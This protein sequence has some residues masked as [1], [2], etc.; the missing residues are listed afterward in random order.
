[1]D[2]REVAQERALAWSEDARLLQA[3]AVEGEHGAA[4]GFVAEEEVPDRGFWHR[5][6]EDSEWGD[7]SAEV[8]MFRFVDERDRSRGLEVVV[9]RQGEVLSVERVEP[10]SSLE[11]V[12]GW[13][14]DS[15]EAVEAALVENRAL[16]EASERETFGLV[17]LLEQEPGREAP[18]WVIAGGGGDAKAGGGG[19][20]RVDSVS[21]EIVESW[22]GFGGDG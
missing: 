11:P 9:D 3:A 1:M 18:T 10:P 21:G 8:W 12:A 4:A 14:V 19:L 5:A 22:G 17:M 13:E 20:V 6:E 16:M 15:D 2:G 7:G